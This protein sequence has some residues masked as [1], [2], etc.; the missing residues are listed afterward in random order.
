[1]DAYN[2]DARRHAEG[3]QIQVQMQWRKAPFG[4][5]T[6][7]THLTPLPWPLCRSRYSSCTSRS[8]YNVQV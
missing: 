1:M 7:L 2:F 8:V 6:H 5:G 4:E 3:S